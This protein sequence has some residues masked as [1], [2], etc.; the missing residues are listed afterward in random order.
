MMLSGYNVSE[1]I[2]MHPNQFGWQ[3]SF[4]HP[5]CINSE[6]QLCIGSTSALDRLIRMAAG[7]LCANPTAAQPTAS[8][9]YEIQ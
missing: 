7:E 6:H 9:C 2:R 5:L 3:A 4:L 8:A 1:C